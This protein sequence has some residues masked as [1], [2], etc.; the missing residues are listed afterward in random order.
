MRTIVMFLLTIVPVGLVKAQAPLNAC[1]LVVP[2]GSV[3]ASDVQAVINMAL[4]VTTPCSANINGNGVCDAVTVQRLINFLLGET[5]LVSSEHSVTLTWVASTSSGVV[6]YNVY[7]AATDGGPYTKINGSI[8]EP[9]TYVDTSVSGGQTYY[10][11]VTAVDG[12]ANESAYSMQVSAT[13]PTP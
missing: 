3:D 11:V 8:V 12:S 2:F 9:L 10:Y 1:D 13:I 7:R 4:G 5:C 6:G